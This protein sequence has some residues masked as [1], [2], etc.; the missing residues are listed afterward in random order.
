MSEHENAI[1]VLGTEFTDFLSNY[2][3]NGVSMWNVDFCDCDMQCEFYSYAASEYIQKIAQE[4]V[5]SFSSECACPNVEVT[6]YY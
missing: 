4:I 1:K 5:A 2:E 6:V 3:H